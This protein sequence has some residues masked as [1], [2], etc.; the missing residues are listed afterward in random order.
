MEYGKG[1]ELS[2]EVPK[3]GWLG[4]RYPGIVPLE[5]RNVYV[6]SFFLSR[7][8]EGGKGAPL[9][10]TAGCR[11]AFAED[12]RTGGDLDLFLYAS[13]TS[14]CHDPVGS[15]CSGTIRFDYTHSLL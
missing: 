3:N 7:L 2:S 6:F 15:V 5:F 14:R 13:K 10:M 1:K 8:V 11:V 12:Q 9:C 4:F